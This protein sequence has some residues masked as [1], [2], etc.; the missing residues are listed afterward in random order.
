M[1]AFMGKIKLPARN[2]WLAGVRDDNVEASN[3]II[4]RTGA[5]GLYSIDALVAKDEWLRCIALAYAE[6]YRDRLVEAY[7]KLQDLFMH[8]RVH[9]RWMSI[10]AFTRIGVDFEEEG[11][12]EVVSRSTLALPP[13]PSRRNVAIE[14]LHNDW[15]QSPDE[16]LR[17]LESGDTS[18]EDRIT[19]VLFAETIGFNETQKPRLISMLFEFANK[20]RFSRN[21]ELM[22][23]V[24]SAI[25]KFAM[26]MPESSF[27]DYSSLLAPTD[28]DTLSCEIELELAKA[29][30]W[31]LIKI[32]SAK[33]GKYPKLEARLSELAS[34]YLTPRLILQDNY[35][36]IVIHAVTAVGLLNGSRRN[37]LIDRIAKL[38][39]DWFSDLFARRLTD[40]IHKRQAAASADVG[41]LTRLHKR[42]IAATR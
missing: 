18:L 26:N 5:P 42:L 23:A 27:E 22:T 29:V 8:E 35:A 17:R 4:K 28:T 41:N 14:E 32:K 38:H 13:P 15:A 34:D 31:R 10:Q 3:I 1:G 2:D 30:E 40:A 9:E 19:A 39:I 37:E 11:E 25:R 7:E 20:H 6:E 21:D 33:V 24:G 12:V 36:S 16:I